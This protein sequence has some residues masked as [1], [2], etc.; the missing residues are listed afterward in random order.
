MEALVRLCLLDGAAP[1]GAAV[2]LPPEQPLI[3][4][5]SY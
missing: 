2:L 5:L 1:G 4:V 3:P